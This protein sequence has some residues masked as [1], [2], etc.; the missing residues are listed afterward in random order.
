MAFVAVVVVSVPAAMA[1]EISREQYVERA[2]GLCKS[3][4]DAATPKLKL[5]KR[6]LQK[7]KVKISG[8]MYIKAAKVIRKSGLRIEKIPKPA[9]DAP[10]L[11]DWLKKFKNEVLLLRKVGQELVGGR[12]VRAQGYLARFVNAGN[13]AN[14]AVFGFGFNHCLFKIA[15]VV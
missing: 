7:N 6:N 11:E 8:R 1:E 5:A 12:R 2:E 15:R 10:V 3:A 9:D 13:Q 14:K 4:L